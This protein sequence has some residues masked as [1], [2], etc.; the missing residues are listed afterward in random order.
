MATGKSLPNAILSTWVTTA[1]LLLSACGSKPLST[2]GALPGGV[3]NEMAILSCSLGCSAGTKGIPVNCGQGTIK[4]NEEIAIEF[5]Q[6]VDLASVNKTTFRIKDALTGLTP[7]GVFIIDPANARR[8]IFRPKI[9]FDSA[10][11]ASFGFELGHSYSLHI[12]GEQHGSGPYLR[13]VSGKSNIAVLNCN[14]TVGP[15]LVDPSPGPSVLSIL[16]DQVTQYGPGGEVLATQE[17]LV[18]GPFELVDVW[19]LS[20]IR[21]HFND[22]ISPVTIIEPGATT[23]PTIRFF[24]DPDGLVGDS[25][26]WLELTGKLELDLDEGTLSSLLTFTP[27]SGLPSAG[28][29]ATPRRIVIEV[30]TGIF[31]LAG[32][33][34]ENPGVYAFVPESQAFGEVQLPAGGEDFGDSLSLDPASTG[35]IV[36]SG[37]LLA[38]LGGGAGNH[39]PLH[40]NMLNSPFILDTDNFE[41]KNFGVVIEGSTVFPPSDDPPSTTV[42]DGIFQFSSLEVENDGQLVIQGSNPAQFFVRGQALVQGLI[43]GAGQAPTDN[44][45][46]AGGHLS[47]ELAGG[48][49]G[50]GGPAGGEGGRGADRPDNT[51][52]T[53]LFLP[54]PGNG[55]PNPGAVEDGTS[56]EGVGGVDPS[57]NLGGGEGGVHWPFILPFGWTDFGDLQPDD[58]CQGD[59][60]GNPGAG[61]GYAT[62]GGD[63]DAIWPNPL[64]N[65]PAGVGMSPPSDAIGGDP[66]DIGITPTLMELSPELGFLRGG[67]GGGG[68]GTH[69]HLTRTNGPAFGDCFL[70]SINFYASHSAGG[71]GGG[72]GAM[73][74]QAGTEVRV[75][76]LINLG[77]GEGGDATDPGGLDLDGQAAPGG[78]GSGGAALIQSRQVIFSSLSTS[79]DI[80]GGEGGLGVGLSKGGVGGAGILR[81]ESEFPVS[82]SEIAAKVK[83]YDPTPG[84]E[85]GGPDSTA[86]FTSDAW[87][88]DVTGAGT[89]SGA[90]SCWLR[91]PGFF[92]QVI[93]KED[94]FTNPLAPVLGWDMSIFTPGAPGVPFS[95]RDKNDI[96]NPFSDSPEVLFGT[97]LGGL[98]PAPV[99]VRFQGARI[100]ELPVN[101]CDADFVENGG[102]IATESLTPW[103]RH[104]SELNTYWDT[105]F[106]ADPKEVEKR[107]SNIIRYCVIFDRSSPDWSA[108]G[109]IE[110]FEILALP[111]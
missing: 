71:G 59:Q 20:T 15:G 91:P 104:P 88:Q 84:S 90:Q 79:L 44:N 61:G 43:T 102:S 6:P 49:P 2:P 101:L 36:S 28:V 96:N 14:V 66:L 54:G 100:S 3:G 109:G 107:R 13:S 62:H 29:G 1:A 56:G 60:V 47:N 7:P 83:P 98:A 24:I 12:N 92:F 110:S 95:Y 99:V 103:V 34:L 11:S 67:A 8:L 9:S 70:G 17:G 46:P 73:Q 94:D 85:F 78:G 10:G 93:Y 27:D 30:V 86:I 23:S 35:A 68:G 53:L 48:V 19:S 51:G 25:T 72:G 41:V 105:V 55:V 50:P 111:D 40:V 52:T 37:Q 75:T 42:T 74:L 77:G 58:I 64:L 89:R 69:V 65:D 5:T 81:I 63:S 57:M 38:G 87:V 97:D 76:G 18:T 39:G 32:A 108:F 21:L 26:D 80:A 82:P 22:I 16:A 4:A 45:S 33:P 31:D 106:P